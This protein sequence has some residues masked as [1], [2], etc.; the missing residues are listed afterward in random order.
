M[1]HL[2]SLFLDV[3][4][5]LFLWSVDTKS[6]LP[7]EF[8]KTLSYMHSPPAIHMYGRNTSGILFGV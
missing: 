6:K 4:V 5:A 3:S 1:F 7:N 8:L 2:S